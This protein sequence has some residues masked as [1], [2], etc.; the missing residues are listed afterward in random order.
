MRNV[1]IIAHTLAPDT[2]WL[3]AITSAHGLRSWTVF[4]HQGDP[5]PSTERP[6]AVVSLG[7]PQSVCHLGR[8]RYLQD[9]IGLL[10]TA[11]SNDTPILGICLGAQLLAQALGGRVAPGRA[12]PEIGYIPVEFEAADEFVTDSATETVFSFHRDSFTVPPGAR[13]VARSPGYPQCFVHGRAVGAQFHPEISPSGVR[14]LVEREPGL[15]RRAGVDPAALC[16][17]A[18]RRRD[19]SWRR[20]QWFI[21][22]WLSHAGLISGP[23]PPTAANHVSDAQLRH[24]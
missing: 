5:I 21:T 7:G 24:R 6:D 18:R 14:R 13:L 2:R 11:A 16:R 3:E 8:Y 22:R 15:L 12:G 17:E 20:A 1:L 10:S 19:S 4:P 9:E 23:V